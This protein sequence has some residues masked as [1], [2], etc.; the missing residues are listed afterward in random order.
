MTNESREAQS[1][2]QALFDHEIL[3]GLH[4]GLFTLPGASSHW[5]EDPEEMARGAIELSTGHD[6]YVRLT[7]LRQQPA[8][9]SRGNANDAAALVCLYCEIDFGSAGHGEGKVYPPDEDSVREL[10]RVAIPL[11]PTYII[12]SGGGWHVYWLLA[13]PMI[14]ASEDDHRRAA[15]L[16]L[17]LLRTVQA[18]AANRDWHVDS[19]FDLARV[20]RVPGTVNH[21][22]PGQPRPVR[23]IESSDHRYGPD[24]FEDILIVLEL[25]E[26]AAADISVR[27]ETTAGREPPAHKLEALLVSNGRF[28]ATWKHQRQ[29]LG[30]PSLSGYDLALAGAAARAGWEDQEIADLIGA[31]RDRHGETEQDR[32]KGRRADYLARTIAKAHSSARVEAPAPPS[33][34]GPLGLKMVARSARKTSS[35]ITARFDLYRDDEPVAEIRGS[36]T[37]TSQRQASETIRD[38]LQRLGLSLDDDASVEL[39]CW[40]RKVLASATLE[41]VLAALQR[42]EDALRAAGPPPGPSMLDIATAYLREAYDL[43][44]GEG[45]GRGRAAW[46]EAR[47]ELVSQQEFLSQRDHHL[48]RLLRDASDY[49][50]SDTDPSKPI[51]QLGFIMPVVWTTLTT[52]LPPEAGETGL[53]PDSRAAARFVGHLDRLLL[54]PEAWSKDAGGLAGPG[55]P[56]TVQ[57]TTLAEKAASKS[58]G[59]GAVG[60]QRVHPGV[61]VYVA[62]DGDRVWLALQHQACRYAIRGLTVPGVTDGEAL[63]TL[64]ARYGLTPGDGELPAGLADEAHRKGFVVLCPA[65]AGRVLASDTE[66]G[67]GRCAERHR[68]TSRRPHTEEGVSDV[69]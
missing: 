37:T 56:G 59:G 54:T 47:G 42:R 48:L 68:Q 27:I 31:F 25:E 8:G 11:E 34:D 55:D 22:L 65:Y 4:L 39:R 17:R 64:V 43:R 30:D 21:K 3:D 52:G 62:S 10:L 14:L 67:A 20:L 44:F 36:N 33:F 18:E 60:W 61:H 12:H 15:R 29:D 57:R 46:S 38:E 6:V 2:L 7:P 1:F 5:F 69:A 53:G 35:K 9:H 23:I 63:R 16:V 13:E 40:V 19:V 45:T 24:D 51:K 66:P 49:V 28:K 32:A 26:A 58:R 41:G 50:E